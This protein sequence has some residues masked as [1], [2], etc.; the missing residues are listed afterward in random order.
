[1]RDATFADL[2]E[3]V[4]APDMLALATQILESKVADFDPSGLP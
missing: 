1:V 4:L 2:P 3:L